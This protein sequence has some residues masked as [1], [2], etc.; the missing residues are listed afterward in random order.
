MAEQLSLAD[1]PATERP[2]QEARQQETD[3]GRS[4]FTR[5]LIGQLLIAVVSFSK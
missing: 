2:E 3:A 5:T 1:V 4:A